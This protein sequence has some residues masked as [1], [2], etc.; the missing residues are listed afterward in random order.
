[1][2]S[3]L[4]LFSLLIFAGPSYAAIDIPRFAKVTDTIYRGSRPD[5]QT[6]AAL[7]QMNIHTILNLE[8]ND[9][10][11]AAEIQIA[12]R[13]GIQVISTPMSGFWRPH[14]NQVLQSLNVLAAGRMVY[15][16]C[17]HGEDRTGLI[18]GLYRVGYQGWTPQAAWLEMQANGFHRILVFLK[19]YYEDV[20]GFEI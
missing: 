5:E 8:D 4:I 15:V 13:Y 1:M 2:Q 20:T 14:E 16:H 6:I 19:Q 18:V 10:A 12:S 11:I 9:E 3:K 17:Q 7:A